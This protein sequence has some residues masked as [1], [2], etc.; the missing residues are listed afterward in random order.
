MHAVNARR[1][2]SAFTLIELLVVIAIIAILAAI[3]FPVFAQAREQARKIVCISNVKQINTAMQMYIQDYDE[4]IPLVGGSPAP[5]QGFGGLG[6]VTWLDTIQPYVKS[7]P[8]LICPDSPF[9]NSDTFSHYDYWMSYGIMGRAAIQNFPN[10]VTRPNSWVNKIVPGNIAYD[11]L[12]GEADP[13]TSPVCYYC[14]N[15]VVP[16]STLASVARPS[17]YAFVFDSASFDS[18]HGEFANPGGAGF[19]YC[20]S[21]CPNSSQN[22]GADGGKCPNPI[23][24]SFF[25]PNPLHS[26][27]SPLNNCDV[28]NGDGY[29]NF[30][31]GVANISFLDGHAKSMKGQAFLGK[32]TDDQQHLYYFSPNE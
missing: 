21:Y 17:E 10:W 30:D 20:G 14:T 29:R 12:A 22:S 13:A 25:G 11:G 9:K 31:K 2:H 15:Y 27:G 7:I 5:G 1:R 28:N 18:W 19:G 32:L 3:L 4:T 6:F 24:M 26:G 8:L 23:N 16:S